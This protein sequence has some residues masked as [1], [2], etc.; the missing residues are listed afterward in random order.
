MEGH[1]VHA[2]RRVSGAIVDRHTKLQMQIT[3]K[4]LKPINKWEG[5]LGMVWGECRRRFL[6]PESLLKSLMQLRGWPA[7][8]STSD[9]VCGTGTCKHCYV[10]NTESDFYVGWG[11]LL[12]F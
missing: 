10:Q 5:T 4:I 3:M 8:T 1:T 11:K 2:P 6:S 7:K 12:S 9:D